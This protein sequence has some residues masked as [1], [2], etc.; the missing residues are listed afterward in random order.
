M[1]VS[2]LNIDVGN[3]MAQTSTTWTIPNIYVTP[4]PPNS[5]NTTMHVSEGPGRTLEMSST[6]NP[7]SNFTRDFFLSHG[8]NPVESQEPFG[9]SKQ[10]LLNIPTGSQA[11]LGNEKDYCKM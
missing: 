11:H 10:P 6:A 9:L 5:T 2:G 8:K 4:I 1:N 3:V 7:K